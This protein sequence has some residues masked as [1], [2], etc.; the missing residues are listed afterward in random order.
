MSRVLRKRLLIGL[1]AVA[2][3]AGVAAAVVMAAKPAARH[4][5]GALA[6]A[7]GYLGVSAAQLRGELQSGKSLAQLADATGGKSE[8][9]LIAALEAAGREKLATDAAKLSSVVTAEVNRVGGPAAAHTLAGR[10]G[11]ASG[12]GRVLSAAASYL[13]VGA[14]QIRLELRAGKT[15]AQVAKTTSGRSEAGLIE[16]LVT[17]RKTALTKAVATGKINQAQAN[18]ALP[19]L[20]K[21]AT[22]EVNRVHTQHG[23]RA[24]ATAHRHR[25]SRGAGTP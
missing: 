11:L 20:V 24:K 7:A 4:H 16:A 21:H 10:R 1:A 22:A 5:H 15:L 25:S 9:G 13:G 19:K 18:V 6:T 17:A 23:S 3:I 2:V 12:R 8:A 14:A